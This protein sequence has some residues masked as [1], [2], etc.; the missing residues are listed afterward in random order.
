MNTTIQNA[1]RS[2]GFN[3]THKLIGALTVCAA[4]ASAFQASAGFSLGDAANYAVLYEGNGGNTLSFNNSY[5]TGNMGIGGTG[6]A[7]LNGPG[8]I[9]GS[10][11]FSAANTGQYSDSGITVTGGVNYNVANVTTAL[12]TVNSL[13]QSLGLETGTSLAINTGS[14]S[15][16]VNGSLGTLD[17]SG[18]RVFTVSSVSFGNNQTLTITGDGHNVVLNVAFAA[19]FNGRIVLAGGL[20]ADQVLINLTPST[21]ILANYNAAY[22]S[23]SGGPT[24]TIST[25]EATLA[26]SGIFLDPTGDYQI[27]HSVL[28]GRLFG[29]DSVNVSIVSG[30]I[31]VAPVPEPTT[32]IAGALLLLPLGASTLRIMRKNRTVSA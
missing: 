25:S 23:L 12:S 2:N 27:N 15:Q 4:L 28:D 32:F 5:L 29:G 22:A 13:S 24:L 7:Q 3:R 11:N 9:T 19:S 14:G 20:T 8:T 10:V 6:Q 18:N 17:G 31:I 16:S 21:A 30:A 26:T 1:T